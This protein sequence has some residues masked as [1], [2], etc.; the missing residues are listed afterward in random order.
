MPDSPMSLTQMLYI[1]LREKADAA[2]HHAATTGGSEYDAGY[3]TGLLTAIT[4]LKRLDP[5]AA[6]GD[7][8]LYPMNASLGSQEA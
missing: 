7:A 2:Q 8:D 3:H 1:E 5:D 6:F 4:A